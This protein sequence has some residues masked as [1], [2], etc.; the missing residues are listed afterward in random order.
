MPRSTWVISG[1]SATSGRRGQVGVL[2]TAVS[3][4]SRSRTALKPSERTAEH[5]S[6]RPSSGFNA[7]AR[8]AVRARWRPKS[9]PARRRACSRPSAGTSSN[10]RATSA[11]RRRFGISR[12]S[13]SG[14]TEYSFAG[15]P[16]PGP[17]RPDRRANLD[18]SSPA[19]SSRSR[20]VRATLRCTPKARAVSSAVTGSA[21][22]R[23]CSS[24]AARSCAPM[25]SR[26]SIS[27]NIVDPQ[28]PSL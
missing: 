24:V 11:G 3:P 28:C 9:A 2:I 12:A 22:P 8:P 14:G 27:T 4:S 26:R 17:V 15:R 19:R 25:P 16:A 10:R 20:R 1:R 21:D 5:T 13:L 7:G 18:S 6:S 23:T